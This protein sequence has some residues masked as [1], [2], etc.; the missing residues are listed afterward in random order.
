MKAQEVGELLIQEEN[1]SK[2]NATADTHLASANKRSATDGRPKPFFP[3]TITRPQLQRASPPHQA[4][5]AFKS[6]R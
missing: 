4:F 5:L 6:S 2:P 3:T 1:E